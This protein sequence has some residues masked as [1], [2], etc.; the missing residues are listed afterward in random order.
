MR[1]WIQLRDRDT[2]EEFS[3]GATYE[4]LD[5]GVLKVVSGSDIHLYSPG[6][7]EEVTVDTAAPERDSGPLS[8][9]ERDARWQ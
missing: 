6:F 3:D 4:V 5:S 2:D 7:W 8:P 9:R 1:L